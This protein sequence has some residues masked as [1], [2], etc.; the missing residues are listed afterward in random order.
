MA[1][2][3]GANNEDALTNVSIS[4]TKMSIAEKALI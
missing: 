4:Q 2:R 3:K 1:T